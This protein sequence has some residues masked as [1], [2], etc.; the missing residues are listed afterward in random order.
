MA[1]KYT[2]GRE[3]CIIAIIFTLL[4]WNG[5]G[6]RAFDTPDDILHLGP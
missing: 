5:K 3:V 2:S 6:C 4:K 1:N